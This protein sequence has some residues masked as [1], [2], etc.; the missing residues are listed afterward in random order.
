M[1]A[2]IP[3]NCQ[4]PSLDDMNIILKVKK[5]LRKI[6][7]KNIY[8]TKVLQKAVRRERPLPLCSHRFKLKTPGNKRKGRGKCFMIEQLKCNI[9]QRKT[10]TI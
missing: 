9:R 6:N 8:D 5:K 1:L 4:L 2:E 3:H 10:N 7:I